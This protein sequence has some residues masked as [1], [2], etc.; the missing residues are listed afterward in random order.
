MPQRLNF[1]SI[2][3][4][5]HRP[6]RSPAVQLELDLQLAEHLDVLGYDEMWFGEHHSGGWEMIGS[7]ELMIVA[8]AERTKNI[9]LG[10]GVSSLPYHHPFILLDRMLQLDNMTRGRLIWGMG[11]GS[12]AKDARSMGIETLEVRRMMEE[13]LDAIHAMLK[14]EGP[15]SRSTDWFTLDDAVQQWRPW[16]ESLDLRVAHAVSP[17]GPRLAGKYGTGMVSVAASSPAGY[18]A[19]RGAWDIAEQRAAE[20]GQTVSRDKWAIGFFMHVAETEREAR[21]EVK[22][23]LADFIR[24]L[25]VASFFSVPQDL[26]LDDA[27]DHMNENGMALVGTP[28]QAIAKIEEI[29]EQSEGFGSLLILG[30]DWATAENTR[31]SY[32]VFA[33]QVIPYFKGHLTGRAEGYHNLQVDAERGRGLPEW[34][35]AIE[36]AQEQH[37]SE[38][39]GAGDGRD[40]RGEDSTSVSD[41]LMRP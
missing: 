40:P 8:A 28:D 25:S 11:P 14:F 16:G 13:S 24:Y 1:G 9:R 37:E 21:E 4:P 22:H 19:L 26:S 38:S 34:A 18:A 35:A 27:I 6:T 29:Q 31:K 39:S 7:P 32:S 36:K 30:Q 41:T 15:V 17:S 5:L 10:T 12:L 33:D 20:F 3:F 2:W 23:G